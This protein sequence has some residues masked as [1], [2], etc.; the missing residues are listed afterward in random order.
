MIDI[1]LVISGI[2][3][4]ISN[5][6]APILTVVSLTSFVCIQVG[7]SVSNS[8]KK[9][10]PKCGERNEIKLRSS[11]RDLKYH[12]ADVKKV[13]FRSKYDEYYFCE[14]CGSNFVVSKWRTFP[15]DRN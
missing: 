10:C 1:H 15:Y 3:N 6:I 9:I 13:F 5:Q 14:I 7:K 12:S 2:W 4:Y 8:F 11:N